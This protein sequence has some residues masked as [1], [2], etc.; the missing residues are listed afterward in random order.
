MVR[1]VQISL[2]LAF[3]A[4]SSSAFGQRYDNR[5][6]QPQQPANSGGLSDK[7]FYGGNLILNFGSS[8]TYQEFNIGV[9][10]LIGFKVFPGFSVGPKGTIIYSNIRLRN[11]GAGLPDA[12][13]SNVTWAV[14]AFARYRFIPQLFAHI[15]Y[16]LEEVPFLFYDGNGDLSTQRVRRDNFFIGGGFY[17]G[18]RV[19]VE[20]LALYNVINTTNDF[21][22]RS[23]FVIRFGI[24]AGF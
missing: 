18:G 15:E 23:P 3:I 20:I 24:V 14:G 12:Q 6:A 8:N 10:P 17:S 21:Y 22:N 11:Q 5:P 13:E 4:I 9:S 19:G 2:F 16:E 7:I 1:I